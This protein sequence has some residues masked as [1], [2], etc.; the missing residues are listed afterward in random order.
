[1]S[2]SPHECVYIF[3]GAYSANAIMMVLGTI[4]PGAVFFQEPLE[5]AASAGYM[6]ITLP[7]VVKQIILAAFTAAKKTVLIS[8][9]NQALF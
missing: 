1:M 6:H 8:W 2:I 9:S 5:R 3:H 4:P 7:S